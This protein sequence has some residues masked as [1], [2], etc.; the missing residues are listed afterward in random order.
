MPVERSEEEIRE[1]SEIFKLCTETDRKAAFERV[2]TI[3]KAR[4]QAMAYQ[5]DP[6]NH[7]VVNTVLGENGVVEYFDDC[8]HRVRNFA[9]QDFGQPDT[10]EP[11]V[12]V[13]GKSI[14]MCSG[15]TEANADADVSRWAVD[16]SSLA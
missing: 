5:S 14:K 11:F 3:C 13:G 1:L 16:H 7:W 4:E 15:P 6:L 8:R 12:E 9:I 10:D 2:A